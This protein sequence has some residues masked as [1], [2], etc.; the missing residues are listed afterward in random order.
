MKKKTNR[1][2][3]KEQLATVM[4][5]LTENGM[6]L[7][8]VG[9][10]LTLYASLNRAKERAG[11]RKGYED[12]EFLLDKKQSKALIQLINEEP[13]FWNDWK[14]QQKIYEESGFDKEQRPSLHRLDPKKHYSLDNIGVLAY[15][16][17]LQENAVVT[18]FFGT[19]DGKTYFE[20]FYSITEASN[21]FGIPAS[22]L[23]NI[24][25]R[26]I[27]WNGFNGMYGRIEQ[28]I[29][30]SK[31]KEE[32]DR[33]DKADYITAVER[34]EFFSSIKNYPADN[35]A[36]LRGQVELYERLGFHL[37]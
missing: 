7:K 1:N 32:Y 35:I 20:Y 15:G 22:K 28:D 18:G 6:D 11:K 2:G 30:N 26:A 25:N 14:A 31:T 10:A 29:S 8:D 9:A 4:R 36:S 12:I 16:D 27:S 3:K 21:F 34:I 23:K 19:K 17:H 33:L 5:V 13:K 37:L 24:E